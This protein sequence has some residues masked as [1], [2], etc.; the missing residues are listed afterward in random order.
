MRHLERYIQWTTALLDISFSAFKLKNYLQIFEA[1]EF[2]L[3]FPVRGDLDIIKCQKC[4]KMVQKVKQLCCF[5]L[6][7]MLKVKFNSLE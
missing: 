7:H 5:F 3:C 2:F 6:L 1:A 4:T